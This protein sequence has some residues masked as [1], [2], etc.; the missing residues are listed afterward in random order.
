[1]TGCPSRVG[2]ASVGYAPFRAV[3]TAVASGQQG[4]VHRA[5]CLVDAIA[6]GDLA[7]A[8]GCLAA[9]VVVDDPRE[10][11][12]AGKAAAERWVAA[13]HAWLAGLS[14]RAEAVRTTACGPQAA[15]EWL[16]HVSVNGDARQL[17]FAVVA[18]SD[19]ADLLSQVRVYHSFWSIDEGHRPRG[20]VLPAR[21]DLVL[22]PP[23]DAY[24][25]ALAAGDIEAVLACYEPDGT[26]REPA[27]E[28]W[29]H[30]GPRGLRRLYGALLWDGG[31][32]LEQGNVVDDGVACALE[33]TVVRWGRKDVP[34]QGGL[35]VYE[36]GASGLI[37]STRIY[38]DVDPP[39]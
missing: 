37:R 8:A 5:E 3:A 35:A 26:M 12:V 32:P 24:H 23:V 14:A 20:R 19:A 22:R 36:R 4:M 6:S 15:I 1:M 7:V 34:P 39:R 30:R 28:P 9:D 17:P 21:S 11:R 27:G 33:Y 2:G 38:D 18:E 10:G 16:L 31:I 29:V 13:E 25:R